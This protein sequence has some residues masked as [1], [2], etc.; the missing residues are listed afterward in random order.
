[1]SVRAGAVPGSRPPAPPAEATAEPAAP[2]HRPLHAVLNTGLAAGAADLVAKA[3]P[4][5]EPEPVRRL[6]RTPPAPAPVAAVFDGLT[7]RY[8]GAEEEEEAETG[9]FKGALYRK[10]Y[11]AATKKAVINF[12]LDHYADFSWDGVNFMKTKNKGAKAFKPIEVDVSAELWDAACAYLFQTTSEGTYF[13]E[14]WNAPY[15]PEGTSLYEL[16]IHKDHP[17]QKHVPAKFRLR[18]EPTAKK[19]AKAEEACAAVLAAFGLIKFEAGQKFTAVL[20]EPTKAGGRV[21]PAYY[22]KHVKLA[23]GHKFDKIVSAVSD[24][25]KDEDQGI[26]DFL[27]GTWN[28][29]QGQMPYYTYEHWSIAKTLTGKTPLAIAMMELR[30]NVGKP[31]ALFGHHRE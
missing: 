3:K 20:H 24:D 5:P 31:I 26:H 21:K 2:A 8:D 13:E 1:M 27:C 11:G 18:N 22:P 6:E 12:Y 14:R 23:F 19:D 16:F 9:M 15:R 29:P 28:Q 7:L 30:A 25:R 10:T 17:V 4:A